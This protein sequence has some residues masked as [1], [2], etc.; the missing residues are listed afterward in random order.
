MFVFLLLDLNVGKDETTGVAIF[1]V[2]F[3]FFG[4]EICQVNN[5]KR[6]AL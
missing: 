3:L 5:Y 2:V 1:F 6:Q 4:S